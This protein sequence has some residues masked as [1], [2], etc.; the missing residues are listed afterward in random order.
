MLEVKKGMN[1]I[2]VAMSLLIASF[3][4]FDIINLVEKYTRWRMPTWLAKALAVVGTV[5]AVIGLIGCFVGLPMWLLVTI[6]ATR[7][8]SA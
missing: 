7:V 4:Q 5:S 1:N 8:V 2:G 3:A 6:A